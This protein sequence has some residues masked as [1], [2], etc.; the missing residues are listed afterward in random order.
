MIQRGK[1][2]RLPLEAGEALGVACPLGQQH[3]YGDVAAKPGI[4]GTKDGTH[5]TFT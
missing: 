1:H 2:L 5:A 3:L 4:A